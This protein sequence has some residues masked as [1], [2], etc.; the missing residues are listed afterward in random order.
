MS[1]HRHRFVTGGACAIPLCRERC[2]HPVFSPDPYG[3]LICT[4]C[5]CLK[6][7][8]GSPDFYELPM[9]PP[10]PCTIKSFS[11][12]GVSAEGQPA[13]SLPDYRIEEAVRGLIG[14]DTE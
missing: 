10:I 4:D 5:G 14:L 13:P 12:Q 7:L 1:T 2:P 6:P 11:Y 9:G 8:S 3:R